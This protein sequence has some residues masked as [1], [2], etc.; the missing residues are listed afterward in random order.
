MRLPRF[1][2]NDRFGIASR[3]SRFRGNDI[4]GGEALG[5]PR[6]WRY[7]DGSAG[8]SPKAHAQSC[9]A[10]RGPAPTKF[11]GWCRRVAASTG[12]DFVVGMMEAEQAR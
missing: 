5:G 1:A 11:E 9:R 8:A 6:A 4:L 12:E 10:G 2:R 7:T 3:D